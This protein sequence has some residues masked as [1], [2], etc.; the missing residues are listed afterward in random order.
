MRAGHALAALLATGAGARA[1]TLRP[2]RELPNAV[3]RLSDLFD[4]LGDTPDRD[5]GT[6]PA[7]ATALLSK[8]RNWPRSPGISAYRGGQDPAPSGPCWNAAAWR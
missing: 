1:A 7:P 6:S 3:V 5:L 4:R 2:F 8:R